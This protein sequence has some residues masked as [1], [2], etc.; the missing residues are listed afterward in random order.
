MNSFINKKKIKHLNFIFFIAF[1]GFLTICFICHIVAFVRITKYDLTDYNCSDLITNEVIR[2]GME[3][4]RPNVIYIKISFY[5]DLFLFVINCLGV[6][7]GII[8]EIL[9]KCISSNSVE[10]NENKKEKNDSEIP[11]NNYY[12]NPN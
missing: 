3:K 6:L 1:T 12:P 8:L 4:N 11:L 9:G 2:K 5:L 7:I 10:I